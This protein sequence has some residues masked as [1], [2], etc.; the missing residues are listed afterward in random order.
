MTQ[1]LV[2]KSYGRTTGVGICTYFSFLFDANELSPRFRKLT[3][4]QIAIKV[5]AEFPKRASAFL[6]RGKNKTSTVNEYRNKYNKGLFSPERTMP[7]RRSFRYDSDGDR[8]EEKYGKKKLDDIQI[9]E[10]ENSHNYWREKCQTK[11]GKYLK[12]QLLLFSELN[13]TPSQEE[14]AK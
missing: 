9:L 7:K 4:E 10:R 5:E 14:T 11:R 6:F 8:V 1:N 3:D 13:E 2:F 12:G